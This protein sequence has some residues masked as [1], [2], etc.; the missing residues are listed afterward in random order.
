MK[1]TNQQSG[2]SRILGGEKVGRKATSMSD[3]WMGEYAYQI[4]VKKEYLSSELVNIYD[5]SKPALL[6]PWD[7]MG[8][9]A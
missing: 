1:M 5:N 7:P 8:A 2:K 3:D 6:S 4:V 9:L